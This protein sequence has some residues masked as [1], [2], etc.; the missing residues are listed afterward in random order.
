MKIL[1][2][3]AYY[4]D[5]AAA[6][7][8]NG[9]IVAASQQERFSRQKHDAR[10]P[11]DAISY[12]LRE[13]S[14]KIKELDNIVFYEKPFIMSPQKI[15]Y[16]IQ[17]LRGIA[18]SLVV[19]F[20]TQGLIEIFSDQYNVDN[21]LLNN[22]FHLKDFGAIGVDI[23]FFVMSGF[24]MVIVTKNK[25]HQREISVKFFLK[26]IFRVVP[27]Y[28]FYTTLTILLVLFYNNFF[29]K[30]FFT[31]SAS[32]FD[33]IT[34]MK[35]IFYS[36]FFIPPSSSFR[37]FYPILSVGWSLNVEMY[38]Y[39][40]LAFTLRFIP[41][42]YFLLFI[43]TFFS[44]SSSASIFINNPG[45]I[46]SLITAPIC[47]EFVFGCLIGV[48]YLKGVDLT[49][50]QSKLLF[51]TGVASISTYIFFQYPQ[52]SGT[53]AWWQDSVRFFWWGI[54]SA[55]LIAGAVFLEK[56]IDY[57]PHSFLLSLGNTSY[58]I[59]LI[60]MFVL[61]F[62][63]TLWFDLN[64]HQLIP[65]DLLILISWVVSITAGYCSYIILEKPLIE[66][67]SSN[68]LFLSLGEKSRV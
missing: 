1:G 27:I 66:Y 43:I 12:C 25:F 68:S 55:L 53:L 17:A 42:K 20:H 22:F 48:W 11:G 47:L 28:W 26:I 67:L 63:M 5:S 4:H 38:F 14:F 21:G 8:I 64:L 59:Y 23:F 52:Y 57:K 16:S 36:Y 15:V 60:H 6:L 24:V 7:V 9:E 65:I 32:F 40:I 3:S 54:P 2:I 44:L 61:S 56:A 34:S 35:T 30:M 13:A 37:K 50:K 10:F 58:S 46:L 18:A 33:A 19:L 49:V 29:S 45:A 51:W 62:I 41:E 39:I 31:F